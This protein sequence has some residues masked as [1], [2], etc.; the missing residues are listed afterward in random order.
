M[1]AGSR[2]QAP[3]HAP[4]SGTDR[5]SGSMSGGN[6]RNVVLSREGLTARGGFHTRGG[7]SGRGS[8]GRG[9]INGASTSK[10]SWPASGPPNSVVAAGFV[11]A[12]TGRGRDKFNRGGRGGRGTFRR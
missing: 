10:P 9:G 5:S 3:K 4:R 11:R 6:I 1:G 12:S 8:S 2:S 7:L